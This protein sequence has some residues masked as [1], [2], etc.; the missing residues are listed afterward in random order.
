[1]SGRILG[2]NEREV[3]LLEKGE[4]PPLLYLHGFADVHSV[5]ES[6][7]DFHERL[8][9]GARIIAPA[10]PGCA[11]SQENGEI[12]AIE[13]VVFHYLEVI[14]ALG[15]ERFDLVGPCVGGWIAAEI[16][17]RHPE[18]IRKIVLIG[19]AGL[20]IE[21][22]PIGDV[23]MMAQ[24][25]RG[26]SYAGLRQMLFASAE[27]PR[28]RDFFPDGIGPIDEELRRYQMLRFSSRVGF[29]P[30]YFYNRSLKNRLYRIKAPALVIWGE[31]DNMV[32]LSHGEAYARLLPEAGQLVTL[33]AVGHSAIVERPDVTAPLILDFLRD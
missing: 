19:A 29:K 8:S 17:A 1:M 24:P 18:K 28:A 16:A 10:H 33:P 23:F 13:D 14:D 20:F 9:Q 6:W 27:H 30:P 12:D 7:L 3:W 32:P 26:A 31:K 25:E 5:K 4:G 2:I 11:Q 21:R 15:L 22:A